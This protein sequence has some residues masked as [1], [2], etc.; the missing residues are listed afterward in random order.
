MGKNR[1]HWVK[2]VRG[3]LLLSCLFG[4]LFLT[5]CWDAKELNKRAVVSGIGIDLAEGEEKYLVSLQIIIADEISGKIGRGATPTS[6]YQARGKTIIDAIR[7]TSRKVPRLVSPAQARMIVMSEDV[8]REGVAGIVDF[9][10][11]D[12]DI[13]LTAKV[14]I[15]KKG[16]SA[17]DIVSA[18]TPI[19]KI[20]G[21][22]LA[23]KTDMISQELGENYSVEVDDV[24]RGLLIPEGGPV[25]NGLTID[26]DVKA[27]GMKSS[28]ESSISP[29]MVELYRMAVFKGDKMLL[30]LSEEEN[31]GLVWIKN[32]MKKSVVV[33]PSPKDGGD[34]SM[35]V[36]RSRTR[37]KASLNDPE[38]PVIRLSVMTQ[39]SIREVNSNIDLRNP[40]ELQTLE[41]TVQKV[42]QKQ[43]QTM[44]DK[45]QSI[46]CD[47]FTFSEA[48]ERAD[49]AQWKKIRSKWGQIFPRV[50]VEYHVDAVIRNSQMRDRSFKYYTNSDQ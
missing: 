37:M 41:Q 6:V 44:V 13:R 35:E 47:M 32:K 18:L 39:F 3:S 12:S 4:V 31:R 36:M 42:I 9:L 46:K 14:Y 7:N 8:A 2:A 29:G 24:I 17:A 34:I 5:G 25:L 33:I 48:M 19:G 26:G 30:W 15:A 45:A 21:Y 23:Q 38:H 16:V 11:R 22:A 43:M 27:A 1:S 28:L 50:K 49:P 40:Y 20:T 10:D